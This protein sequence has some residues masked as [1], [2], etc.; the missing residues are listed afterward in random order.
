MS[1]PMSMPICFT[2]GRGMNP[3]S[4]YKVKVIYLRNHIPKGFVTLIKESLQG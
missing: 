3:N 1:E 4:P 2:F